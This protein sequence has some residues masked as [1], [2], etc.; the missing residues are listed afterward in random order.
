MAF[1]FLFDVMIFRRDAEAASFSHIDG[2]RRRFRAFADDRRFFF[3]ALFSARQRPFSFAASFQYYVFSARLMILLA[4]FS[5]HWLILRLISQKAFTP[6]SRFRHARYL[7]YASRRFL[8]FAR[9]EADTAFAEMPMAATAI[10]GFLR[11]SPHIFTE[12]PRL[13]SQLM[14]S[15][16]IAASQSD[17]SRIA[18]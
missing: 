14:F 17:Y 11:L 16:F 1:R 12:P 4:I 7:R 3:D 13:R 2:R 9:G 15:A 6:V 10:K 18:R 8:L 5:S